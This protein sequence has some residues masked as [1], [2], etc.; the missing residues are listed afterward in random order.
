MSVFNWIGLA[1]APFAAADV[2]KA[3]DF[4]AFFRGS[5]QI[6][7]GTALL[8]FYGQRLTHVFGN[9]IKLVSCGAYGGIG[10]FL[11]KFINQSG[12]L[13][14]VLGMDGDV[15][16]VMGPRIAITYGGPRVDIQRA[17]V[18]KKISYKSVNQTAI[19]PSGG[20]WG[21]ITSLTSDVASLQ[22]AG[23][24]PQEPTGKDAVATDKKT[25][26]AILALSI[27]LNLVTASFELAIRFKYPDF[28]PKKTDGFDTPKI[29]NTVVT[30]ISN[31]IL[32]IIYGIETAG[33]WTQ[34][35][36]TF[37][38]NAKDALDKVLFALGCVTLVLP[39]YWF[40]EWLG[41]TW[42]EG[43]NLTKA[44][45]IGIAFLVIAGLL[46]GLTLG[47]TIARK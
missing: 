4:E 44:V 29:L 12:P 46:I 25:E 16:V 20:F 22:L 17:P 18:I 8:G 11:G 35:A 34:Y 28:D 27:L 21:L 32:A 1:A 30:T 33:T 13:L 3:R 42:Q 43:S 7:I 24:Q 31:I 40:T 14:G 10:G 2:G 5:C 38:D 9:E 23:D 36:T 26:R 37:K 15:S 6:T 39:L 45:M 47:M 19:A 41:K